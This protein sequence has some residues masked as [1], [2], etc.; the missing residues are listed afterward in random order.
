LIECILTGVTIYLKHNKSL[1]WP[2]LLW[3][4]QL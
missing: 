3:R 1:W 4:C 2:F